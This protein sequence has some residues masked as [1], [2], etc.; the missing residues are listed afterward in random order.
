[1]FRGNGGWEIREN[2]VSPSSTVFEGTLSTDGTHFNQVYGTELGL[3]TAASNIWYHVALV[4]QGSTFGVATNGVFGTSTALAGA[5]TNIA[6]PSSPLIFGYVAGASNPAGFIDE[7]RITT[8]ARYAVGSTFTPPTLAFDANYNVPYDPFTIYYPG[9][10]QYWLIYGPQVFVLTI[11]GLQGTKSWSRYIFPQ[12]ITD[13][14]LN[15]G[16]LFLRTTGSLVWQLQSTQNVDDD[17]GLE[18]G[19]KFSAPSNGPT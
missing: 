12:A 2:S 13:A 17:N 10:G 8:A 14:T 5:L 1:M 15:S 7:V 19:L 4:R 6:T 16:S 9:R 18:G 11:N 3:N